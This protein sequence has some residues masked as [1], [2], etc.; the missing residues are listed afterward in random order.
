MLLHRPTD[1]LSHSPP[2]CIQNR[3]DLITTSDLCVLARLPPV[4]IALA[5]PGGRGKKKG[6]EWQDVFLTALTKAKQLARAAGKRATERHCHL[7]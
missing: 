3:H 4:C 7:R 2:E 1:R 5:Q 6:N